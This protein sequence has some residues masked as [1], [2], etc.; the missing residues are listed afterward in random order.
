M[1]CEYSGYSFEGLVDYPY[2]PS[3]AN[4]FFGVDVVA[5]VGTVDLAS[6]A[7]V[8]FGNLWCETNVRIGI[9]D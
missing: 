6:W 1:D 3:D 9:F 2:W 8:A 4:D 7:C 5:V